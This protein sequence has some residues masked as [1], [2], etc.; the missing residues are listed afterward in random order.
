MAKESFDKMSL[1]S[2]GAASY[3]SKRKVLLKR[4]AEEEQRLVDQR[5]KKEL[6]AA[7]EAFEERCRLA[8]LLKELEARLDTEHAEAIKQQL[9]EALAEEQRTRLEYE[10]EFER[11]KEDLTRASIR[12]QAEMYARYSTPEKLSYQRSLADKLRADIAKEKKHVGD[13]GTSDRLRQAESDLQSVEKFIRLIESHPELSDISTLETRKQRRAT[14]RKKSSDALS[15][16]LVRQE[17]AKA[18]VDELDEKWLKESADI[19]AKIREAEANGDKEEL[20]RQKKLLEA[21][22]ASWEEENDYLERREDLVEANAA[23]DA[24]AAANNA[25]IWKTNFASVADSFVTNVQNKLDANLTAIY[26]KQGSRQSRLMGA[27]ESS[28]GGNLETQ[29]LWSGMIANVMTSIGLSPAITQKGVIEKMGKLVD[30]GIAYNVELRA[31]IAEASENIAATFNAFDSSLLR[32]IRIQQADTT[33][34]RLGME[35]TLTKLLNTMYKDSSFM[36]QGGV[37][38]T[39]SSTLLNV[40]A[41]M[42]KNDALAFEFDVQKWLGAL[43]SL[44]LSSDAV[45]VITRG[46]EYLGTG[47]VSEFS[48]NSS[49][50]SL[51]AMSASRVKDGKSFASMLNEGL[52][53]SDIN[54]L[55]RSMVEYLAEIA[56]SQDNMVTKSAYAKLFG[57]STTDL[58]VFSSI[59][60]SEIEKLYSTTT[61]YEELTK[62][63]K[64]ELRTSLLRQSVAQLVDNAISNAEYGAAATI[65][66]NPMT[67]GT[68]KALSTL[69]NYVGEVEIPGVTVLG[70][71][72]ASGLDLINL[73]QTAM[74]GMGL[75]G[76]LIAAVASIAQGGA[77]NLDQ[78][79]FDEYTSRGSSLT[80]L[81]K[82]ANTDVSESATLGV[83][84]ASGD[85]ITN[86]SIASA[87]DSAYAAS[88]TTSEEVESQQEIPEKIYNALTSENESLTVMGVLHE[89]S[90]K[91]D[92]GRVFYT[93]IAGVASNVDVAALDQLSLPAITTSSG[94]KSESVNKTTDTNTVSSNDQLLEGTGGSSATISPLE[95]VIAT[96]VQNALENLTHSIPVSFDMLNSPL[97]GIL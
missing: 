37:S 24:A 19:Q 17:L 68:W 4:D 5:L 48:G 50:Q 77:M 83:G 31:F 91:L 89:I 94:V 42:G 80:Y 40:S 67:Y 72:I 71:G 33:A 9:E 76:S 16:A 78:W 52:T 46:I 81:S 41:T 75:V 51:F 38:D 27:T 57:L 11:S 85:D 84:S 8:R 59:T 1:D 70:N 47:N 10:E 49:L 18:D 86:V 45:S 2:F 64:T 87:T 66:S 34:A 36:N 26:D 14:A 29:K 3:G 56:K 22:R 88:G 6:E 74:A 65:G 25:T 93:A 73:S 55:L 44:G 15:D 53:S 97:G 35:S 12:K 43:Y 90:D 82:G 69:K 61:S 39:I 23:A 79:R 54:K 20:D 62:T 96:A 63:L 13:G 32:L 7:Q 21:K 30:E 60:K 95:A 28:F 58:S 92:Y